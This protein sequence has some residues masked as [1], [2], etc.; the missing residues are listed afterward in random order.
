MVTLVN[1]VSIILKK[2]FNRSII[3]NKLLILKKIASMLMA[4][5]GGHQATRRM[6]Q[7]WRRRAAIFCRKDQCLL[8]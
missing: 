5:Y 1:I 7:L 2:S 3:N 4:A 8:G 6:A